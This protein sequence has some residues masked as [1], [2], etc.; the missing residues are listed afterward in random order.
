MATVNFDAT[1]GAASISYTYDSVLRYVHYD[2]SNDVFSGDASTATQ[3]YFYTVK[4]MSNANFG[5]ITYDPVENSNSHTFPADTAVL[6]PQTS[7]TGADTALT[8]SPDPVYNL[9]T[10]EE[11]YLLNTGWKNMHGEPLTSKDLHKKFTMAEGAGFGMMINFINGNLPLGSAKQVV[12]PVGTNGV[13]AN[14]PQGCVAFRINK[15]GESKIRVIVAVPTSYFYQDEQANNEIDFVNDYY[16]G[17]WQVEEA[18]G[19]IIQSF[20]SDASLEKFEIPRSHPY[21]PGTSPA[22]AEYITVNYNGEEYRSY[23]GGER[24]L[25][26]YEFTV[27]QEGVYVLGYTNGPMEIVYFSA[28]GTASAGRDGTSGSKLGS[29]DFVY[30]YNGKIIAV[31][32]YE[33]IPENEDYNYFYASLCLL[34]TDNSAKNGDGSFVSLNQFSVSVRRTVETDPTDPQK[35]YT[36]LYIVVLSDTGQAQ[37]IKCIRYAPLS[38]TLIIENGASN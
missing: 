27:S 26:A 23:L 18:G 1:T 32:D 2:S 6:F 3:L 30:E 22:D 5:R 28:D 8:V 10:L 36:K 31:E 24:V 37:Y 34:F 20:D 14:I 4:G 15:P 21:K 33:N 11:L 7:L 9:Y 17:V 38:D 29:V 25:V 16:L 35:E 13:E 19:S 12:A